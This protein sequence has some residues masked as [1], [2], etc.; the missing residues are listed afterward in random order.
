MQL[1]GAADGSSGGKREFVPML[2]K[3]AL[4]AGASGLFLET[5]PD[6]SRAIS[7]GPSQIPLA[8]FEGL[9]VQCLKVWK[10]VR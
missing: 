3:A 4:A 1:P 2:A 9:V 5:H 6:P 7:D 10:A 8:E